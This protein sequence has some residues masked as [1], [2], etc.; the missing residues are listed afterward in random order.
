MRHLRQICAAWLIL[1]LGVTSFSLAVARGQAS[2]VTTMVICSGFGTQV[3]ALDENGDP[4]G[5]P[6][7]CPDGVAV[8]ADASAPVPVADVLW[9]ADG[10]VIAVRRRAD[11]QGRAG[12]PAVARGPPV[13]V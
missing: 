7:I 10:E 9:R 13:F 1:V 6:H 4:I 2:P 5:D 12:V 3:I 11:A 8:F